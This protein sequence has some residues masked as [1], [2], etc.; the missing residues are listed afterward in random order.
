M[1]SVLAVNRRESRIEPI[2]FSEKIHDMLIDLM[3]RNFGIK[4]ADDFVR[5]QFA[6]GKITKEDFAYYRWQLQ[7]RKENIEQYASRLTSDLIAA[8]Y[9]YPTSLHEYEIRRDC[10]NSAICDCREI[11]KELQKVVE[12]FKVDV[13]LFREVTIAINREIDLIKR[14]RQRDNKFKSTLKGSI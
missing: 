5:S 3:R 4:N 14:W 9:R 11:V 6:H 12:L 2:I 13:N 8:Y 7:K 1:S 10:Q